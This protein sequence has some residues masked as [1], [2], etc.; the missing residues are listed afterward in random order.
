MAYSHI[1]AL[2]MD[3]EEVY[4]YLTDEENHLDKN[5]I[6]YEKLAIIT[7]KIQESK[8]D[9]RILVRKLDILTEGREKSSN[10]KINKSIKDF[11]NMSDSCFRKIKLNDE[12][13]G[14]LIQNK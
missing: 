9:L 6:Y 11:M 2:I 13:M 3:C 5:D 14:N 8:R 1:K 7:D 4:G 12:A 10:L